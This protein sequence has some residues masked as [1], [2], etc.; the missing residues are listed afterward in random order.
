M[1]D[2][3]NFP[4]LRWLGPVRL[5][6]FVGVLDENRDYRNTAIVGTRLNFAPSKHWEIGLNRMQQLCGQGRPCGWSQISKS[7]FGIGNAD[8]VGNQAS[9]LNQPGNQ[10][11][12][13]DISYRRRFG[14]IAA[15]FYL[16]AE[17]EDS[18]N[19]IIEQYAR[20]V[21]MN[22]AG[23]WGDRGASWTATIEYADTYGASFFNGTPLEK[24]T[25]GET[26]YPS[27]VYN[28]GV[29]TDGF[30]YNSLPIGYWTDGD[31][32]NLSFEASMTDI[33]N[34]RWY[35]TVRSV[36][37]NI[38]D[39]GNPPV[40]FPGAPGVLVPV[41]YRV[42]ANSEKFAILTGGVYMPTAFGDLHIEARYRT[43]SPNTP[44]QRRTNAA[45]EI[46]VHNQF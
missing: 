16:E 37:L 30:T 7:F 35:G 27:S 6:F 17:A 31:S 10:I 25:G 14:K 46:S 40:I 15:K 26:R 13:F 29:Y 43:D 20:L 42:S 21:G 4:V 24:L 5:D 3:I 2:P 18:D 38:S 41:S 22:L 1:P 32:R 11:A 36:H 12:G 19:I 45:I 9:F 28:N 33:A 44:N 23:P 39:T 8:N 34:R